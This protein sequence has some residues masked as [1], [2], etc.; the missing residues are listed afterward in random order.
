[1]REGLEELGLDIGNPATVDHSCS[2]TDNDGTACDRSGAAKR[3][4][5]LMTDGSPN[6]MPA[7]CTTQAGYAD[8]WEGLIGNGDPDFECAM[9]YAQQAAAK[10]VIVYTIGIGGGANGDYLKTMATGTDPHGGAPIPM[11]PGVGGQYFS[12]ATPDDL[13]GIFKIILTSISVRIVG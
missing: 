5:I 7:G 11:F 6:G 1:M 2:T 13:D 3:V 8:Y 9:W 4:L 10:G 12:A